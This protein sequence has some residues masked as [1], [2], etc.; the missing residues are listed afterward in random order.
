LNRGKKKSLEG[1]RSRSSSIEIISDTTSKDRSGSAKRKKKTGNDLKSGRQLREETQRSW[2]GPGSQADDPVE[3]Y[4]SKEAR[5]RGGFK[6]VVKNFAQDLTKSEFYSIFVRRGEVVYCE[7]KKDVGY[8]TFKTRV[9]AANAVRTLNGSKTDADEGK[10]L[11]VKETGS[12]PTRRASPDRRPYDARD[13]LSTSRWG[14]DPLADARSKLS[15]PR[16]DRNN[17]FSKMATGGR[18]GGGGGYNDG[19]GRRHSG[20]SGF[21]PFPAPAPPPRGHMMGGRRDERSGDFSNMRQGRDFVRRDE[22]EN[23]GAFGNGG[24]LGE[25]PVEFFSDFGGQYQ[26]QGNRRGERRL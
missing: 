14:P 21:S 10:T 2:T 16:D 26:G 11:S 12:P 1:D 22:R 9:A 3:K 20:G 24:I 18:G 7:M 25:R 13:R 15:R 4:F 19:R 23:V 17:L 8:V 6:V 5:D